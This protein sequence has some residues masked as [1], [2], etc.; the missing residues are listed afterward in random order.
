MRGMNTYVHKSRETSRCSGQ[1]H[2]VPK[3]NISNVVM[4][5]SNVQRH[6]VPE[7]VEV[8]CRDVEANVTTLQR[9]L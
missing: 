1:R 5:R 2:D 4:L 6:D 3:S 7:H 8:Y 9:G